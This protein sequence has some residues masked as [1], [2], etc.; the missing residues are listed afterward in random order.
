[1]TFDRDGYEE[2]ESMREENIKNNILTG[3]RTRNTE[4]EN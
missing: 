1:M 2:T 3:G 4:I